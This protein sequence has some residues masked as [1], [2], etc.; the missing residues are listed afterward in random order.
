LRS[1]LYTRRHK[2]QELTLNGEEIADLKLWSLFLKK[3]NEGISMNRVTIRQPWKIGWSDSCPFGI[4]GFLLSGRAWQV[5]IP[6][7]SP[8]YGAHIANNVLEFLGMVVTIWLTITECAKL[9]DEQACILAL[10]DNTSAIGWL[11]KSRKLEP[12]SL[13]YRPVQMIA[14]KLAHLITDSTHCLASQHIQGDQNT[15]S[16]LL[17]FDGNDRGYRHPLASNSPPDDILTRRFHS[18]IP[19]MIPEAFKISPLPS[20]IS[21]FLIRALQ[22]IGSSWIRSKRKPTRKRTV[23]G[24][25]GPPSVPPQDSRA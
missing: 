14:R 23:P 19:Q 3:A 2:N 7:S 13:Y 17:S 6:K 9:G 11:Y 21:S 24:D 22:T 25:D 15:V 5:K 16:D 12:D 10:G 20:E 8:I 18:H 1:R 4:G